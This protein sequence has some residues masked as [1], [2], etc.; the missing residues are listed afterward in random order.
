MYNKMVFKRLCSL[1]FR[2]TLLRLLEQLRL[3]TE[4]TENIL[5]YKK[6]FIVSVTLGER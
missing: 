1:F 6:M 2:V 3:I 5:L 4:P